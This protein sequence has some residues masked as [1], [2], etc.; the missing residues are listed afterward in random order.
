MEFSI[1]QNSPLSWSEVWALESVYEVWCIYRLL[2]LKN[3]L[4]KILFSEDHAPSE[5]MYYSQ[6]FIAEVYKLRCY[7]LVSWLIVPW[8]YVIIWALEQVVLSC[9]FEYL[10]RKDSGQSN[11]ILFQ[12]CCTQPKLLQK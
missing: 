1:F 6:L 3:L 2:I 11:L 12:I 5:I 7:I 9:L 4:L 10:E 8:K